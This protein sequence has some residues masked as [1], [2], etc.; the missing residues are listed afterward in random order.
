[1]VYVLVFGGDALVA[2]AAKI[3]AVG[4]G[5]DAD[6]IYGD[7][8]ARGQIWI[9]GKHHRGDDRSA[10]C[11]GD[12]DGIDLLR[13]PLLWHGAQRRQHRAWR[14]SRS[15]D[16]PGPDSWTFGGGSGADHLAG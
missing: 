1:M 9:A 10:D 8:V 14:L 13:Q 15:A 7:G 12:S 5:A 6:W 11:A 3:A 2:Y 16:R 4:G